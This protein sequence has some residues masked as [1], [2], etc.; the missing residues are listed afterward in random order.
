MADPNSYGFRKER[1]TAD[2]IEQCHIVLSNRGGARW[3]FEGDIKSCF[4]RI[5]HEWLM[6][7][8]PMCKTILQKWLKA[9]FMEKH[10]FYARGEGTPE[11]GICS[12]VLAK[13]AGDGGGGEGGGRDTKAAAVSRREKDNVVR[14]GDD[15][16]ITGSGKTLLGGEG[17]PWGVSFLKGGGWELPPGETQIRGREIGFG[18]LGESPRV[19]GGTS[20]VEPTGENRG[21]VPGE[22]GGE[23]KGGKNFPPGHRNVNLNPV[24]RG[25]GGY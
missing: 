22:A 10:V 13:R 9:G 17:K 24:I 1:S 11:G 3:I 18:F 2:A 6:A 20:G 23:N 4:D 15:F 7:H 16:I 19:R 5:S 21:D 8:I 12:P 25:R 14:Y